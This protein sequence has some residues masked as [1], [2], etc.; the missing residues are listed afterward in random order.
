LK[1]CSKECQKAH[2]SKHKQVCDVR[3]SERKRGKMFVEGK[4]VELLLGGPSG[5]PIVRTAMYEMMSHRL[6]NIQYGEK[7]YMNMYEELRQNEKEWE[8]VS[9]DHVCV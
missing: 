3:D 2:W 8:E 5:L 1:D 9:L 4:A 7:A 6:E